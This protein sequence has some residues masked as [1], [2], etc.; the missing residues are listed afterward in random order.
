M[1]YRV[2]AKL[3]DVPM[4]LRAKRNSKFHTAAIVYAKPT[5]VSRAALTRRSAPL[6]V[7]VG[8]AN[9]VDVSKTR[10]ARRR[11][12]K[13]MVVAH[14]AR[15]MDVPRPRKTR[16]HSAKLTVVADAAEPMVVSAAREAR[17]S[18]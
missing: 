15:P 10:Q 8:V 4:A 13:L 1:P 12:A 17:R 3:M 7:E 5:D 9:P 2:R 6:T 11:S 14:V 16:R 18:A